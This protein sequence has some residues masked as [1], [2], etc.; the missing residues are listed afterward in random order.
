M[1]GTRQQTAIFNVDVLMRPEDL[2]RDDS[3]EGAAKLLEVGPVLHI[4]HP[5]GTQ[6]P[7]IA[8]VGWIIVD[9]CLIDRIGGLVREDTGGQV[10]EHL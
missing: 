9:H 4:N 6:I 5:L 1:D 3:S 8:A 2:D 7:K 10:G